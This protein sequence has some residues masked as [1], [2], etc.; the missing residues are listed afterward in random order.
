MPL[1]VNRAAYMSYKGLA[2]TAAPI[3]LLE[4]KTKF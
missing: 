1:G 4:R 3:R 2:R